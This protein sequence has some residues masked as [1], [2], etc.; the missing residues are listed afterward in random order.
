MRVSPTREWLVLCR[1]AL[2]GTH[3]PSAPQ[4]VLGSRWT[5]QQSKV[6]KISDRYGMSK[7]FLRSTKK[8][9]FGLKKNFLKIFE[10]FKILMIFSWK[11]QR[12]IS[13]KFWNFL[14]S[15]NFFLRDQKIFF[16]DL[17]IFFDI[18]YRSEILYTFNFW[19]FGSD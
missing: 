11:C 4:G 17:K 6:D 5:C 16:V 9:F 14:K 1:R 12:K 2:T 13:M 8:I 10:N 15:R 7:K 18:P 19:H 3:M